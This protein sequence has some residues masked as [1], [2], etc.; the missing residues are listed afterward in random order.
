MT[1][2]CRVLWTHNFDPAYP[3][4]GVFM[5]VLAEAVRPG[6]AVVEN[7]YLG[8]LRNPGNILRASRI[9]RDMAGNFDIV[10]AQF[11]SACGLA[12]SAAEARKVLTLR[13]SDWYY[14]KEGPLS[15][16]LHG[17]LAHGM[18][19]L[20]LGR[21]DRIIV[22][23]ERM[24]VDVGR[25]F[26]ASRITVIPD[27]I[28]LE[29]FRP[30]ERCQARA[31]LGESGNRR[32]WVLFPTLWTNNPIKRPALAAE[33]VR[34]LRRRVP[35]VE[36]R[37]ISKFPHEKMPLLL[38]AGTVLLLTSTHEGWPN[39]VKEAMACNIPFVS[40][41]V[42]DLKSIA[43]CEPSCAVVP[44]DPEAIADALY[45]AI[46]HPAS[47]TLRGRAASMDKD[48]VASRVHSLYLEMMAG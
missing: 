47:E 40:T 4:S 37:S 41:D 6:C 45:K 20:S 27:G 39:I 29:K 13:G 31:A 38:S 25:H 21:Y 7:Q 43:A 36:F 33:A 42:S 35:D 12:S 23:S 34:Y 22:M 8:N 9:V 24:K 1:R 17:R 30:V 10:H 15:H 48:M 18:T 2:R 11:G 3:N 28:D 19:R 46:L 14:L 5:H 32:P 16:R 26:D 44:A